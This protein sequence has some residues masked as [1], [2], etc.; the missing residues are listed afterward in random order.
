MNNVYEKMHLALHQA[1]SAKWRQLTQ[2]KVSSLN[3]YLLK[4]KMTHQETSVVNSV[5]TIYA[6][7]FLS[8]LLRH[9]AQPFNKRPGYLNA[10]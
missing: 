9:P 4:I 6:F 2:I 1:R 5:L 10:L 7:I 8:S 3:L